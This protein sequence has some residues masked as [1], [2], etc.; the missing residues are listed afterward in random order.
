M[1]KES[2]VK[3]SDMGWRA[4]ISQGCRGGL[5][6]YLQD[7]LVMKEAPQDVAAQ[8]GIKLYLSEYVLY[9]GHIDSHDVTTCKLNEHVAK[10]LR[11]WLIEQYPLE[12][13]ELALL[14]SKMENDQ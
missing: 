5:G 1:S 12:L 6:S 3:I 4:M 2:A 9:G 7:L 14:K 10:S 13:T 8:S 11:N